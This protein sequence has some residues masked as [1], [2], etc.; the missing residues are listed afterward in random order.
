MLSD[1]IKALILLRGEQSVHTGMLWLLG[2]A[3]QLGAFPLPKALQG[4]CLDEAVENQE[5]NELFLAVSQPVAWQE[6][7]TYFA[8]IK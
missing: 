8:E 1:N 3:R 7:M 5:L 2:Q 6:L 4:I